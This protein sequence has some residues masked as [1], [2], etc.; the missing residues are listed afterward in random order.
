MWLHQLH[1]HEASHGYTTL[2]SLPK[3][4]DSQELGTCHLPLSTHSQWWILR[5]ADRLCWL[6]RL[7]TLSTLCH[8]SQGLWHHISTWNMPAVHCHMSRC[9]MLTDQLDLHLQSAGLPLTPWPSDIP[10]RGWKFRW[11]SDPGPSKF[12]VSLALEV[13]ERDCEVISLWWEEMSQD[14]KLS[15]PDEK[16]CDCFPGPFISKILPLSKEEWARGKSFAP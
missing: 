1:A 13:W 5:S 15:G 14:P 8:C 12:L 7:W 6:P 2:I 3:T 9:P 11:N 16:Q 10:L 4:P